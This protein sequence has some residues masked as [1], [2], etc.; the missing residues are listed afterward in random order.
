[1]LWFD[2]HVIGIHK[3]D[4]IGFVMPKATDAGKVFNAFA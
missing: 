4:G 3:I 2:V 1:M